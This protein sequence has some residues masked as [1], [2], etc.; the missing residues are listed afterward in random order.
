MRAGESSSGERS[1]GRFVSVIRVVLADIGNCEIQFQLEGPDRISKRTT[2]PKQVDRRRWLDNGVKQH[3]RCRRA[4]RR[5]TGLF[6]RLIPLT[7]LVAVAPSAT[8]T[9]AAISSSA[10]PGAAAAAAHTAAA[11]HA[12]AA[13]TPRGLGRRVE[14]HDI[15]GLRTLRLLDD[16]ELDFFALVEDLE[17]AAVNGAVMDEDVRAALALEEAVALLLREP[18]DGTVGT[19]HRCELLV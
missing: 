12:T 15:R 17:A 8:T 19:S 7:R 18:F 13:L 16:V 5:S 1:S 14:P 6:S 10:A 2:T 11:A 4:P 3:L 9:A